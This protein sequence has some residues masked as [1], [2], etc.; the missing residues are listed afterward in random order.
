MSKL[1]ITLPEY[2]RIFKVVH[3]V[4]SK[5][6][7]RQGASCLFYNTIGALLVEKG[8]GVKAR[9]VMGAAF[10]RV[11][12]VT[13]TALSFAFLND[14]ETCGSSEEAFHCWVETQ[15]FIIDFTAPVYRKYLSGSPLGERLPRKMFQKRKNDMAA[16]YRELRQEGH[17]YVRPNME[18]SRSLLS[19][20]LEKPA[21]A[22]LAN[23]CMQWF[24]R[25]PK[26]IRN[27][28]DI[29]NDLGEVVHLELTPIQLSGAW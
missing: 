10:F 18:I 3:S 1:A 20:G 19:R 28:F 15:H 12:D 5:L 11:D 4:S 27:S 9:P 2:E 26:P 16:S 24:V 21:F 7:D 22:D 8:L 6:D 14:D 23:V 13:N 25:P 17:Y 29:A